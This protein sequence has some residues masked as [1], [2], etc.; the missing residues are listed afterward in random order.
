MGKI[1]NTCFKETHVL[2]TVVDMQIYACD[3]TA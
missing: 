1:K 3:H 2:T